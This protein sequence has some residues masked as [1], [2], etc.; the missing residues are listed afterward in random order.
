MV[1]SLSSSWLTHVCLDSWT[2]LS[3]TTVLFSVPKRIIYKPSFIRGHC[4]FAKPIEFPS[5]L[6]KA[7]FSTSPADTGA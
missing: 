5:E 2:D 6:S 1:P 7:Q 4:V 3:H